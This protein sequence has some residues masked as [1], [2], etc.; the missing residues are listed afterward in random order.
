MENKINNALLSAYHDQL[1]KTE[2]LPLRS[3]A[4]LKATGYQK[5]ASGIPA[6]DLA[7]TPATLEN[8]KI[9]A[10]QLPGYVDDVI[11]GYYN[12]SDSKFYES[13]T[14][15]DAEADPVTEDTYTTEITGES[16]K[17]YIDLNTSPSKTYRWSGSAFVEIGASDISGVVVG[18]GTAAAPSNGVITLPVATDAAMQAY[19]TNYN[20]FNT[21]E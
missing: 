14:A 19:W 16:G 8:G 17:L 15:G 9:P 7:F 4:S 18:S 11:E 5:P 6:S 10:S 12:S 3:S 13:F 20:P 1:M 21:N 2:I